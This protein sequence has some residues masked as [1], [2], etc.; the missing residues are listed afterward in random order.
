[1]NVF[2]TL[3]ERAKERRGH[4]EMLKLDDHLLY[5]IGMTRADVVALMAG[6]RTAHN[7][8]RRGQ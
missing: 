2:T 8:A 6:K 1:M 7:K 3:M 5:D 4:Y